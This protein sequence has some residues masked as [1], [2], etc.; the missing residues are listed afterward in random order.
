MRPRWRKV[1]SDLWDNKSRTLLV[2]FSIAVGVFAVGMIAG[3]YFIISADL[4]ISYASG[5]PANIHITTQDFQDDLLATVKNL[6][7]VAE[8]E[9]RREVSVRMRLPGNDWT[10]MT[11]VAN[12]DYENS[13]INLSNPLQGEQYPGDRQIVLERKAAAELGA[14]LGDELEF[15]LGDGTIR[16]MPVVGIVQDQTT[17]AGDFL[18]TPLAFINYNN[19]SWLHQPEASNRLLVT[20]S[21]DPNDEDAIRQV[22]ETV[23]EK[24]EQAGLIVT[25]TRISKSNEHPMASIVQ[26]VLG[27]LWALGVLVVFLSSSLIANTLNGLL[28]QHLRFI[29]VMK[30]VG[31]RSG[32]IFSM[33]LILILA[34]GVLALVLA[35]PLGIY[36]ANALS[37]FVADQL[38]FALQGFRT[39]P[40]AILIQMAIALLVPLAAGL[41]PVINGSRTTVQQAISGSDPTKASRK[42]G[43][44][45]R[46]LEQVRF[47]SR[48]YLISLRN[49]FRRRSRLALTLAT[50]AMGGAIFIAVFNVQ[51]GLQNYIGQ[52]GSYFLADVAVTF[53][54]PYRVSEI[55]AL[56]AQIPGVEYSEGWAIAGGEALKDDGSVGENITILAPPA[57]SK[58]VE[59]LLVDGRWLQE[60]D[61]QAVTISETMLDSFPG[62]KAGDPITLKINGKEKEWDVVG[63]FQ[64]VGAGSDTT[65]AYG[66]YE[67]ISN[68]IGLPRQALSYRITAGCNE[69]AQCQEEMTARVDSYFRDLG[70]NVSQIESGQAT[71]ETASE[72]L[73]ILTTFLLIMALLTAVVGSIGLTGTMGMN[74]MERTREIGVMRSIGAVDWQ[75]IKS[76]L[77][78]GMLI[79]LI[80]FILGALASFP[81]TWMLSG[82]ISVA[83]FETPIALAFSWQGFIIWLG[84]VLALSAFASLLP[85]RS[86]ARL[87]IREVLAYE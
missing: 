70:Y 2:V 5:N 45:E 76:V 50:L 84:L 57:G 51:V 12:Q 63:I 56:A 69:D 9:G 39:I 52:I 7:G 73:A 86:A 17:A 87:T 49:T 21:T 43:T 25:R 85:A 58:L 6:D 34:F 61:Q 3:A 27:I 71:L 62:I 10:T 24:L 74:V 68:E 42:K 59:P 23:T 80:S 8:A 14:G 16:S 20:V 15:E 38:N 30:L 33:Y 32:Q 41:V 77:F 53:D 64:F 18:A 4:S 83:I 44:L 28:N 54:R 40:V 72:S 81:I 11:L 47:L 36:A 65:L 48:P 82:I 22:S 19:L 31:A 46:L 79:G 67:Y 37:A 35:I 26:A 29:G 66:N 75:V 13:V 60:G 55:N 78:E 1:L